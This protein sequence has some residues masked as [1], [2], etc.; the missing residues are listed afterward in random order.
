MKDLIE[1]LAKNIVSDDS[2]VKVEESTGESGQVLTLSV[3]QADMGQIIGKS[4][5]IIKAIR[6][7]LKIRAIRQGKRVYLDLENKD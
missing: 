5:R 4:G 2:K 7:L 3:A 6:N 1:F